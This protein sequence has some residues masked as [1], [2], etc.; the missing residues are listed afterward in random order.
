MS[1]SSW[2]ETPASMAKALRSSGVVTTPVVPRMISLGRGLSAVDHTG[3]TTNIKTFLTDA[4][5]APDP[6]PSVVVKLS[7][8]G[9]CVS[10]RIEPGSAD[11]GKPV[12]CSPGLTWFG[13]LSSESPVTRWA[14]GRG[15]WKASRFLKAYG[16]LPKASKIFAKFV[17]EEEWLCHQFLH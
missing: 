7:T 1:S 17:A 6:G 3:W 2:F 12:R 13:A 16:T 8:H 15:V 5:R 11:C 14:S 4:Y 10:A 9:L